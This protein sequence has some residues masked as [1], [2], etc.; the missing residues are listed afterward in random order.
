M[1]ISFDMKIQNGQKH[2]Q[3][4]YPLPQFIPALSYKNS[5]KAIHLR[6]GLKNYLFFS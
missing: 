4:Q 3:T 5:D 6:N 2:I 1:N